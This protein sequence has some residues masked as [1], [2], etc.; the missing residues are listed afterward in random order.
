LAIVTFFTTVGD[1]VTTAGRFAIGSAT[2]GLHVRGH[3]PEITLFSQ[4]L[5]A[6]TA[7]GGGADAW[8]ADGT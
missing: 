5:D 6:V 4:F 3:Q 1:V 7:H 2:V 8:G